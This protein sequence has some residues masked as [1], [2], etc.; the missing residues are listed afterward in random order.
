MTQVARA[1]LLT[2]AG[3]SNGI[4]LCA[5]VKSLSCRV[6]WC[7]RVGGEGVSQSPLKDKALFDFPR[8]KPTV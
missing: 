3:A 2:L 7:E 5:K 8:Q 6:R 4:L 1:N